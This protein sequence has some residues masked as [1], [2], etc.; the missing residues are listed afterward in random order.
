MHQLI[1][2][3]PQA[4][5]A[6]SPESR[7]RCRPA[8]G[9]ADPPR[10]P[11][12]GPVE[13]T[14][15]LFGTF[16]YHEVGPVRRVRG[17]RTPAS[18][19]GTSRRRARTSTGPRCRP[20]SPPASGVL[21]RAGHRGRPHRRRRDQPGRPVDRPAR[22]PARTDAIGRYIDWK[23]KA[24]T[25]KDGAVLG[26][27]TDIGPMGMCYRSDLLGKAGLPTDPATLAAQM[28]TWHDFLALGEKF[29]AAAPAGI[30][31]DRLGGRALQRDRLQ[32]AED[33][34]RRVRHARLRRPTR[35]SGRPSTP[36][37][38]PARPGSPPSSSSSSTPAG[39]RASAPG[40][41]RHDRLPVL[42]DRLHQG[43][44]RRRRR[45]QVERHRAARRRGGNWGGS[46]LGDPGVEPAQGAGRE[47]DHL[48]HRPRAAG[49]RCSRRSATSR[50]PPAAS[51]RS[52]ARPTRTS[53]RADRQ[54]LTP[55][56][57]RPR[58][59]R[60]SAPTTAC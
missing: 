60:S 53:R 38:G 48:A 35:P 29:K 18:R 51:P 33:L 55:R 43:Q 16:G 57:R 5:R 7:W 8:A 25:T 3:R 31:L 15:S 27:G 19:S 22:H 10:R 23:E 45:G 39:T 11:P 56:P 17:R 50:P 40:S 36:R 26:L 37:R 54:D 21:R 28:P 49:A 4:G 32:P 42:D 46:Y 59:C 52:P 47:A 58:R 9:P 6:A 14:V 24:A 44:G 20:G 1:P 41:V 34:L 13:L 12:P 30:G 2:T